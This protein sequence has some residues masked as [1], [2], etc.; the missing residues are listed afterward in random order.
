MR[1][2]PGE[3]DARNPTMLGGPSGEADP[4]PF[5]ALGSA[6]ASVMRSA[7]ESAQRIQEDAEH[8]ARK[9]RARA[10]AAAEGLHAAARQLLEDAEAILQEAQDRDA[11]TRSETDEYVRRS[12]DELDQQRSELERSR[13]E[14][15]ELLPV[16]LERIDA[17][18][19]ELESL[20]EKLVG[21]GAGSSATE[22]PPGLVGL[23]GTRP[24]VGDDGA[25]SPV[26]EIDLRTHALWPDELLDP[27]QP[28]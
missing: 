27:N 11:I 17:A 7:R 12:M 23:S 1:N 16:A 4:D 14:F 3:D 21:T 22:P 8:E 25:P 10:E 5:D 15:S 24:A 6:I 28:F 18:R 19:A 13:G 2:R 26:V 9:I 20:Q